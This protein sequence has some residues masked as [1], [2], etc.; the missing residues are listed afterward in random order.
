MALPAY[1]NDLRVPQV[2]TW[3]YVDDT[4]MAEIVPLDALGNAYAAT[5]V[6]EDWSI[7]QCKVTVIEFKGKKHIFSPLLVKGCELEMVDGAK[8]RGLTVDGNAI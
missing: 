6:V 4:T 1:D 7:T 2:Q 3:K 5:K 8:I